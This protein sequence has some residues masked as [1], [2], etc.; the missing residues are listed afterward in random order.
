MHPQ[1]LL[2]TLAQLYPTGDSPRFFKGYGTTLGLLMWAASIYTIMG[3]TFHKINKKRAA[4]EETSDGMTDREL[5][6]L[7][8]NSP[9]F[10]YTT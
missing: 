5:A 3:L 7:G 6:E 1:N 10:R 8:N 2:L 9:H 4:M